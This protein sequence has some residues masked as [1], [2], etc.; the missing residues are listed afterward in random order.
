MGKAVWLV[1]IV[2]PGIGCVVMD[3]IVMVEN[4]KTGWVLTAGIVGVTG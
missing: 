2:I 1:V 3:G 4:V